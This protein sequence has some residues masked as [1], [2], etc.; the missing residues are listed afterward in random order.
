MPR[1]PLTPSQ[2][3]AVL[4]ADRHVLVEAGAGTG[5]TTTVVARILYTLGVETNGHRH[6]APIALDDL[7][8]IT[9]T[10]AAAAELRRKLRD[11]LRDSGMREAAW[12]VDGA[13]IGTIHAFCGDLLRE[14]ALRSGRDPVSRVLEEGEGAALAAESVRD[15]LLEILERGDLPGLEEL[16]AERKAG[17]V[18]GMVV[19]LV[20]DGDRLDRIAAQVPDGTPERV[21]VELALRSRGALVERL[22]GL[23]AV[24]FDRMITWT[25]DLL[26]DDLGVRRALQRRLKLLIADEFQDVDPVQREIAYLLG[27]PGSGRADTPRL[28]LVGDPKQSIYRFRRADVTTWRSV[29]DDFRKGD[30]GEGE[31]I[32]LEE[33]FRSISPVLGLVDAAIGPILDTPIEGEVLAPFEVQFLP[34]HS[35]RGDGEG[36]AV[37]A[38]VVD[39]G[40]EKA[41]A[42]QCRRAEAAVVARRVVELREGGCHPRDIA[43]LLTSWSDATIYQEAL[44]AAGIPTYL[45]RTDG[46]FERREV[47]DLILALEVLRD[48]R[49]DRALNGFLRSPF[50]GVRDETLLALAWSEG[51]CLWDRLQSAA[52]VPE[53]ELCDTAVAH[54][55]EHVALRDR[56]QTHDLLERLLDRSG[57]LAH[58]VRLGEDGLQPIANVRKFIGLAREGREHPV[59]EFLR[60]IRE[61]VQRGDRVGDAR[62]YGERD[63]VVTISSI[64][65]AKGLEWSV[66]FW[67]DLARKPPGVGTSAQMLVGRDAIVLKVPDVESSAQPPAWQDAKAVEERESH[68][69]SKR[70]WYVAATRAKD[71]LIL[72]GFTPEGGAKGSPAQ[73]IWDVLGGLPVADGAEFEYVGQGGRAFRGVVRVAQV[74]TAEAEEGA[75]EADPWG[76]P[77]PAEL[78]RQLEPIPAQEGPLRHSATSLM[79]Y[80]RCEKR[81]WLRYVAGLREPGVKREGKGFIEAVKR[82]QIVH[83][84]LEQAWEDDRLDEVLEA[85]IGRW[86]DEAPSA[87]SRTGVRYREH[88]KSEIALVRGH[89]AYKA[90]AENPTARHELPFV[91]IVDEGTWLEGKVDMAALEEG[92]AALLDLK[93]WQ[94][95]AE[96]VREH[97][98]RYAI[99][100]DVYAGAVEALGERVSRFVF[101]YS[102]AGEQVEWPWDDARRAEGGKRVVALLGRIGRESPRL[103]DHPQECKWCGFREAG[104]CPGVKVEEAE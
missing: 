67:C 50:V 45:L 29:S 19:R 14:F 85:A 61:V 44:E 1:H 17:D 25:R 48:P 24:D 7:A 86:D 34:V 69:E 53:R 81:H 73:A 36:P 88:L 103:T 98:E 32:P 28:L 12:G 41:K 38:I 5:K 87:E 59:G 65:S 15:T 11:G 47:Q 23:G 39:W 70:L 93:T 52:G 49:D 68:A 54:I 83:D 31:V 82:G 21:V 35:E 58:L 77:L 94:G 100:R 20:G 104:W 40:D 64:H 90:L 80:S 78:P 51:D 101:H 75:V 42:E 18:E 63:D 2:L 76:E 13:R 72:G 97:A 91:R 74:L 26:R 8:A 66:V 4:A 84:V 22:A 96:G 99:Q 79:A 95:D 37:E 9:F 60:T 43:V 16:L 89:P 92:G 46:F 30:G 57:Y 10:N 71:R 33:N 102:R 27:E 62:L 56:I 3:R 55:L 6:P